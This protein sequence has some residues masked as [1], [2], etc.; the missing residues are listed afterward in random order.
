MCSL[1]KGEKGLNCTIYLKM[2][3]IN[4]L[5]N[6]HKVVLFRC[7]ERNML[8]KTCVLGF[9][10]SNNAS[11]GCDLLIFLNLLVNVRLPL[12]SATPPH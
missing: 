4:N 3:L 12:Q 2:V 5:K 6:F 8:R 7:K 10:I 9:A 1:V 11:L